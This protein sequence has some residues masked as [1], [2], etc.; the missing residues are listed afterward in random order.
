M[1]SLYAE[2]KHFEA[3]FDL[4]KNQLD[5]IDLF[6]KLVEE[7]KT[8]ANDNQTLLGSENEFIK[9]LLNLS[10]SAVQYNAVIPYQIYL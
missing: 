8:F 5:E 1:D 6:I 3:V 2:L 9:G 10:N 4:Y 7:Q